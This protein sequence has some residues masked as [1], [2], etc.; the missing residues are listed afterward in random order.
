MHSHEQGVQ[1]SAASRAAH[2]A[3]A[4]RGPGGGPY[5]MLDLQ[6]MAGNAAVVQLLSAARQPAAAGPPVQVSRVISEAAFKQSTAGSGRRSHSQI[7]GVDR[8]LAAFHAL[9]EPTQE[10]RLA[11]L[12]AVVDAC[13]TYLAAKPSGA[14]SGGVESLRRQAGRERGEARLGPQEEPALD[15]EQ[16]FRQVLAE[17]DAGLEV[18][19]TDDYATDAFHLRELP[20]AAQKVSQGLTPQGFRSMM[21]H[22]IGQLQGLAH[23]DG[24]PEVTRE[25]IGELTDV[26][27]LVT[28]MKY[29]TNGRPGM[30][31]DRA[32]AGTPLADTRYSFNVDTQ[33]RGGTPFLLGHIAHELTHVAA[34][35]AFN[36]SAV[37][38]LAPATATNEEIRELAQ[39]R[40][41]TM[42]H[43][44][45]MAD[46]PDA[47][48]APD[49]LQ[50][51][52]EKLDYGT[53]G[54]KLAR[55]ATAFRT[56]GKI[57]EE[58]KTRLIGWDAAAGANS[59]TLVEYDTVLNQMLV[60]L[61]M[62]RIPQQN[63]FY[64]GLREAATEAAT[65]RAEA[66]TAQQQA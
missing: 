48:F 40:V 64:A 30:A 62:W 10:Q 60:W 52:Q 25:M 36:S 39:S 28:T 41:N 22:Y 51:L 12:G 38:A 15:G 24:L 65:R 43:L 46:A 47:G 1:Q 29:P 6:R 56:A 4:P 8:A 33:V 63:A 31:A 44:R 13:L 16:R 53:E 57:T 45:G 54:G 35:Q 21:D 14:R 23:D 19:R 34:H 9:R 37:M 49:Q 7:T 27:G 11:A 2:P 55:Y 5:G 58:E 3:P 17:I 42:R 20:Q 66:R 26:V 59:G 18:I 61:H 32:P 50:L